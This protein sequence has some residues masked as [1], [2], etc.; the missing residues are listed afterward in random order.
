MSTRASATTGTR[1]HRYRAVLLASLS[2]VACAT[3]SCTEGG[4]G[5]PGDDYPPGDTRSNSSAANTN[6]GADAVSDT[7][8]V[9]ENHSEDRPAFHFQSGDLELGDFDYE[10]IKDNLFD[11]C[12]E[13]SAEEFAAVGLEADQKSTF[14]TNVG[15]IA[16]GID[17][18]HP[19]YVLN[20][21]TIPRSME[22]IQEWNTSAEP[23]TTQIPNSFRYRG[24]TPGEETCIVAVDTERGHVGIGATAIRG[25]ARFDKLC[26]TA[27]HLLEGLYTL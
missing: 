18:N 20:L 6:S 3:S 1:A 26:E 11:P 5:I 19:N 22:N 17:D 15:G 24:H 23:Y 10:E 14:I 16:C 25:G 4:T 12:T 7:D 8:A 27:G 9:S 13:I 2:V 21:F